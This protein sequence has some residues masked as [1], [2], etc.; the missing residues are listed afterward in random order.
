MCEYCQEDRDGYVSGIDKRG[1]YFIHNDELIL[2]RYGQ[3]DSVK[4]KYCPMCGRKLAR[5]EF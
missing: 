4:I 5:L 3:R 2:K 1:H